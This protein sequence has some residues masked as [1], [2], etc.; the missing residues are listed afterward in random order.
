MRID[1]MNRYTTSVRVKKQ[2]IVRVKKQGMRLNNV[3]S[4]GKIYINNIIAFGDLS[5]AFGLKMPIN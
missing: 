1:L 5:C 4:C 3:L 2:G